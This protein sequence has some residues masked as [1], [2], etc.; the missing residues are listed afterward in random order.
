MKMKTSLLILCFSPLIAWAQNQNNNWYF[1]NEAAIDF[2]SGTPVSITTSALVSIEGCASV[3]DPNTGSLLFYTNGLQIWNANNAPMPNGNGLLGGASTSATQGV[4]IV[5]YP[6]SPQKYF[7]FTVDES[8]NN[9]SNGFRYSVIDMALDNGLGDII[10]SQKNILIQTNS[11]ERLTVAKKADGRGFWIVIHERGNNI[12]KAYEVS[13]S[14]L[15]TTPVLSAVGLV[16]STIQQANGDDTMGYMKFNNN[17]G[18]LAIAIYAA[19]K[20]Q[21][22]DFDN[23]AGIVSNPITV[24]TID[25]PYGIEFSP[26]DTKLYYSIYYNAGL[27]GAIYQLNM[28]DSNIATSSVLVGISSSFNLQSLGALQLAP[29][30]NIYIAV[31]SESWLS[32][33]TAPNNLGTACTFVDQALTLAQSG[34]SPTTGIFGLPQKVLMLD[35]LSSQ[36]NSTIVA[37]NLCASDSTQFTIGGNTDFNSIVWNFGDSSSP[38]NTDTSRTSTH[39]YTST[40]TYTVSAILSNTC[41]NDTLTQTID[42]VACDTLDTACRFIIPNTFTPNGDGTNDTFSPISTCSATDYTFSIFNRWGQQIFSTATQATQWDGKYKANDCPS[43]VYV[44]LIQYKFE[45]QDTQQIYG[46]VSLLR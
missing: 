21:I 12:F 43:D 17:F 37:T 26:D 6:N 9:G 5:P 42:I 18:K 16:H 39:I 38:Q 2:S 14:G 34:L 10:P 35:S 40:G 24:S 46:D 3:S 33:I 27:N 31:N 25:N 28:Q 1:G 30:E 23:C 7:V 15:N 32:A 4:V 36:Q 44:Y 22:F 11:T 20:I 45:G 41:R 29:D 19:S 13:D 8:P